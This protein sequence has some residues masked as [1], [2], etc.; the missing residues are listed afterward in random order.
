MHPAS[1]SQLRSR[2]PFRYQSD[3]NDVLSRYRQVPHKLHGD[4]R[5]THHE[6]LQFKASVP[7][8]GPLYSIRVLTEPLVSLEV[9]S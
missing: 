4:H 9:L 3:G 6:R 2:Y 7:S 5:V 1:D 8:D